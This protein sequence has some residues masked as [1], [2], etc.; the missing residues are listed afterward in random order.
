M[1]EQNSET[2]WLTVPDLTTELGLEVS[3]VRRLLEEHYLLAVRVDGVLKV[4]S[5]FIKDGEPVHNLRGTIMVLGDA[6]FSDDEAMDWLL[7]P[8]E[9]IGIAPIEALRQG[10]RSEVRR[11]AQALA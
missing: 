9:S 6:G 5:S 11:V 7:N 2:V 3:R 4:P 8:E 1:T 10:R